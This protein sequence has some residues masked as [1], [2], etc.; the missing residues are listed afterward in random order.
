MKATFT[1]FTD[2]SNWVDGVVSTDNQEYKFSA[3]LFDVGSNYGINDGRVSKLSIRLQD[4]T[5]DKSI[6]NYDR[7]WDI[8]PKTDE[9]KQI[10]NVIMELL[11][12]SPK[13]FLR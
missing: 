1:N 5:W 2:E 10:F 9:H 7:G 12:N 13:R 6:V 11:E 3:K 4:T 8:E